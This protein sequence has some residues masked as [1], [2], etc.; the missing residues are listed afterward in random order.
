MNLVAF[1]IFVRIHSTIGIKS[2]RTAN[3]EETMK[4]CTL[5]AATFVLA[6]GFAGPAFAGDDAKTIAQ[7]LDDQW[8]A[9]YNKNEA[10]ALT[11]L[12]TTD[13]VLLPQG[14]PQPIMRANNIHKFMSDM[15]KQKLEHMVL[16]VAEANMLDPKSLYQ[17]GT[18]E[19]DAGRQHLTGTYMSVIVHDGTNWKYRADTW[20]M[21]PVEPAV[22][23]SS[24][25]TSPN[26]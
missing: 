20:N 12:Y 26:K 7:R 18:W 23:A 21:M 2:T 3:Q 22:A 14:S 11:N 15:L 4:L 8:I 24:T 25:T 5:A 6:T 13:A 16:P 9:A 17:A 1:W 19:A 10:D